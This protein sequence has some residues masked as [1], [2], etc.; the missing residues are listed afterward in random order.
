MVRPEGRSCLGPG[1]GVARIGDP[2]EGCDPEDRP[3]RAD[4]GGGRAEHAHD[5]GTG[6]AVDHDSIATGCGMDDAGFEQPA[7]IGLERS[8]EAIGRPDDQQHRARPG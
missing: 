6:P 2:A 1:P 4:S 7:K 8:V 3:R 5:P